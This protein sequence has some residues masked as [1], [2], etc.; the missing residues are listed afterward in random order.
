MLYFW[1]PKFFLD[2]ARKVSI[3]FGIAELVFTGMKPEYFV[4]FLQPNSGQNLRHP[5]VYFGLDFI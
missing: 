5:L 3:F 1:L 2:E 4:V